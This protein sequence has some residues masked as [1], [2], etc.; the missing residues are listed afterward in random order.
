MMPFFS[1]VFLFSE[2]SQTTSQNCHRTIFFFGMPGFSGQ[3]V[4]NWLDTTKRAQWDVWA[5]L[6]RT[7]SPT[8]RLKPKIS[9]TLK[10]F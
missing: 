9:N 4:Q 7:F 2:K 8:L 10:Y 6:N 5:G 1:F 3:N